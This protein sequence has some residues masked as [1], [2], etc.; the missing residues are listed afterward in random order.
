MSIGQNKIARGAIWVIM[1]LVVVGLVGF[2]SFNFGGG[3][4]SVGKVGETPVSV[5]R[6]FREVNAQLDA[7][8][9]Q[10]GQRLPFAQ[11]Q[12]FGVDQTALAIV[13]SQVALENE[14]ARLGLSV[15]D[16]ELAGRIRDIRS[17]AG[18]DGTFDRDA[19][20]FVLEQSGL[21]AGEF[22][23]SLRSEVA[24]T[25]L[26][27]AVANGVAVQ[28][29]Y[30][31]TLFAWARE[32]RDITWAELDASALDAPVGS[33]DDAEL[34]AYYEANPDDFT[35]PETKKITY[36]WIRP[37][38]IADPAA[39]S[40]EDLR[41]EYKNRA[42]EFIQPERRL[43]ERLVFPDAAAATEAA[44]RLADGSASFEDLVAERG[45]ALDDIDLGDIE[46][47]D[48]GSQAGTAVFGLDGPGTT[49]VVDSSFGPAIFRVNAVLSALETSFED[50]REQLADALALDAARR[51][52]ADAM[53]HD[54]DDALAGGA[55]IEDLGAEFGVTVETLDWTGM[56]F[57]GIAA[58]DEFAKTATEVTV[59][60]YPA[61]EMLSDGGLFALRLDEVVPPALQPLDE[62][63]D[64]AIA[65]WRA[66]ETE[67]RIRARAEAMLDTFT[68]GE[69]PASLGLTETTETGLLRDSEIAGAPPA[70]VEAAFD[71]APGEWAVVDAP[72]GAIVLRLD[73]IAAADQNSEEAVTAKAR[74]ADATAQA[75]SQDLQ[76]AF[77][78]ALETQAGITLD[79]AMINAVN[80][81]FQ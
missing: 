43:V 81:Q 32:A 74:F 42:S 76:D 36:G 51:T 14:T 49:G 39:V 37:E 67:A 3:G 19:Y 8:E 56:S 57:D 66:A 18:V 63:R 64:Q 77:A 17:F 2:G 58:Y 70:L 75:V 21:T 4:Q 35:L 48:L 59:D 73:A 40:E 34:T 29:V 24:R 1:G 72:G 53:M 80:A 65:G 41:E 61:V 31:S 79:Q 60:D 26:Q 71:L 50:A 11:A 28:P 6:Y 25:I 12:T 9:Q 13:L 54:L 44:A 27:G 45:L 55:T 52:L 5:N 33:P 69:T 23:E 30:V 46:R 47:D 15:G 68:T 7:I 78:A 62:V 16:R 38:D 20:D 22:E 10:F